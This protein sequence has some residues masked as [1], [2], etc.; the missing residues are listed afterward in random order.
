MPL[1]LQ[2]T[3]MVPYALLALRIITAIVFF[4]SGKSHVQKPEERG[5]QIG[6]SP[7]ATQFLG[8]VEI[9][10]AFSIA[11]GLFA[12]C[13]AL[14]IMAVMLGAIHKKLFIWKTDF[15]ADKGY[16]WHYDLTWFIAAW[17]ILATDGGPFTIL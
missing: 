5:Q 9:M 12:Q 4:S 17:V 1:V 11:L 15:Y 14:I 10:G 13:G 6:M 7:K 2:T 8:T 3:F 16:G